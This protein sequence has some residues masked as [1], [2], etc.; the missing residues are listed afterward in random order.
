MSKF[1]ASKHHMKV[2][3]HPLS[4]FNACCLTVVADPQATICCSYG[5]EIT[6]GFDCVQIPGA[7]KA[8]PTATSNGN[9]NQVGVLD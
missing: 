7:F 5:N 1:Y 4:P 3:K 2:V 9:T 8:S 6:I